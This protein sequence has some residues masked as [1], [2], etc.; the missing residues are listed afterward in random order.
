M[1]D[2]P[3]LYQRVIDFNLQAGIKDY[4]AY[5][6]EWWKGAELQSKLLVEESTEAYEAAKYGDAV[7]LLDGL[8]DN[9]VIAFKLAD[10][11]HQAG[12]DVIG[13][14]D[15]V[16]GNNDE[17]IFKTYCDAVEAKDALEERDDTEYYIEDS[18]VDGIQYFTVRRP[19]GKIMKPVDF[20]P[21]DLKMFVPKNSG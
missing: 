13:A 11:L 8:V 5:S 18:F 2:L 19:D 12:F 9:L 7:E 6:F 14:F 16:C 1:K 15:A 17:K 3:I 20:K 10:M 4:P 21:V